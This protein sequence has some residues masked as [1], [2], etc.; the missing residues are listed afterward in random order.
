MS[1]ATYDGEFNTAV[2][3]GAMSNNIGGDYNI[4]LGYQALQNNDYGNWNIGIGVDSLSSN[5]NG[6]SNI[7]LGKSSLSGN[8][9]GG[10]NIGIGLTTLGSASTSN[11]NVAIGDSALSF[12]SNSATK[13]VAIGVG[14]QGGRDYNVA[15][16]AG[17]N[18]TS[19]RNNVFIGYEAG[20]NE[21]G[22]AKLYI[23]SRD[24]ATGVAQNL[25]TG[26]FSTGNLSLGQVQGTVN[27]LNALAVAGDLCLNGSNGTADLYLDGIALT[28]DNG[29][30]KWNGSAVGSGG[31]S[32]FDGGTVTNATTFSSD[33]TLSQN[34]SVSGAVACFHSTA[35]FNDG[36]YINQCL[37]LDGKALTQSYGELYF[38]GNAVGSGTGSVGSMMEDNVKY[39]ISL[40]SGNM[41]NNDSGTKNIALGYDSAANTTKVIN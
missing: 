9:S 10:N 19:G 18:N 37:Y 31:G 17:Y 38:D 13:N 23:G 5:T 16:R 33:V 1:L 39:N 25:I 26:D 40:G 6:Y 30:L 20:Y 34:L 8:V 15:S 12:I 21:T 32:I 29:T 28:N 3:A 11:Y 41:S 4:A 27:V 14:A 24:A 36:A 35:I 7:A 2:G 22:S